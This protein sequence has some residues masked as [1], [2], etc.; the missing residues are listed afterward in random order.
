MMFTPRSA[1]AR[2]TFPSDPGRLS[3]R[4]VNSLAMGTLRTSLR[5]MNGTCHA[6]LLNR[7]A[8]RFDVVGARIL[9]LGLGLMQGSALYSAR[10]EHTKG[11]G[12]YFVCPEK[13]TG[14][15]DEESLARGYELSFESGPSRWDVWHRPALS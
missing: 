9:R 11:L 14:N 2:Q 10:G 7:M 15:S 13:Q 8:Q 12:V 5:A 1:S 3:I 6:S 4:T